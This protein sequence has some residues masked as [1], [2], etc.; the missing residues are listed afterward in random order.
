MFVKVTGGISRVDGGLKPVADA[1]LWAVRPVRMI[2]G[3][4]R[5][6]I[7]MWELAKGA[8][9]EVCEATNHSDQTPRLRHGD[10]KSP[11]HLQCWLS[12]SRLIPSS[13]ETAEGAREGIPTGL[14]SMISKAMRPQMLGCQLT[15]LGR[16]STWRSRAGSDGHRGRVDRRDVPCYLIMTVGRPKCRAL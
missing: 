6:E 13:G 12:S 5:V 15:F 7:A 2:G 11:K 16:S 9:I 3:W 14:L 10:G 4:R 8:A 1:A